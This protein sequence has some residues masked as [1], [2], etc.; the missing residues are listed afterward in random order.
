LSTTSRQNAKPTE[1]S[2]HIRHLMTPTADR[3]SMSDTQSEK[4][5]E[6]RTHKRMAMPW[7]LEVSGGTRK[8]AE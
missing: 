6:M 4:V 8:S 7:R 2:Y 1:T 3:A 5:S